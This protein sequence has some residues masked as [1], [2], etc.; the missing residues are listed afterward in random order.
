MVERKDLGPRNELHVR[1]RQGYRVAFWQR[2][3]DL[4]KPERARLQRP[5]HEK[6]PGSSKEELGPS[7]G[8]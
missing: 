5:A 8:C 4:I 3:E 6:I 7:P 2:H 1:A